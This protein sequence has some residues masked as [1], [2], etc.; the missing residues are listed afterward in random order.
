[1]CTW[2]VLLGNRIR[3]RRKM[4]AGKGLE[5]FHRGYEPQ[6][7]TCQPAA[8]AV[9]FEPTSDGFGDRCL[10]IRRDWYVPVFPGC[11]ADYRHLEFAFTHVATNHS[12]RPLLGTPV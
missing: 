6:V 10:T 7:G 4:V 3:S 11:Q 8:P 2:A 9:G 1:M 5:P 12:Q